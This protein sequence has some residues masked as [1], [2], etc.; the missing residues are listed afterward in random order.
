MGYIYPLIYILPGSDATMTL[1]DANLTLLC[2]LFQV[3]SHLADVKDEILMR[4]T[5]KQDKD[6]F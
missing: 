3:G 1:L 5:T 4:K 6:Y 2:I